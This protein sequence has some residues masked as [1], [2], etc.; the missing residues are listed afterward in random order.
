[1]KILF[2]YY[3]PSGGMDTLNR[4]RC[5]ALQNIGI[6]CH[7]LYFRNGSGI[8][9]IRNIPTFM[10]NNDQEIKQLIKRGNYSVIIVC[11]DYLFLKKLRDFGYK[12][13]IIYEVQGLGEEVTVNQTFQNIKKQIIPYVN[14]ILYPNTSHLKKYIQ[15]HFPMLKKYCFHNCFDTKTFSYRSL[16]VQQS[17]IIGWVGRLERNKNWQAFLTISHHLIKINPAIQIWMFHDASLATPEEKTKFEQMV[18]QLQLQNHLTT[19]SNISHNQMA[20]HYSMI[21]DSGGFLCSTSITEG[22][23]YAV[24]EAMAC[25]CPVLATDSDGVKSFIIHNRTGKFFKNPTNAVNQ[26]KELMT[27][28]KLREELRSNA[29]KHIQVNF[30]PSRYAQNFSK[31]LRELR[32]SK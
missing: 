23:G 8:Q 25:R 14:G 32:V 5:Q 28:S 18:N 26:A 13:K 30:Q 6:K 22:F 29:Q 1:M 27:N 2:V 15:Q 31:M 12:G 11:S 7:L 10:T 4:Q 17:P 3:L 24:V 9:N 21:G 20:N 16:P 19:Y